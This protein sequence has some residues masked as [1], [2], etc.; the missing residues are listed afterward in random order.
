M[1]QSESFETRENRNVLMGLE[2]DASRILMDTYGSVQNGGYRSN[3]YGDEGD[4]DLYV[5][6]NSG[7]NPDCRGNY[8]SNGTTKIGEK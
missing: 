7:Y 5:N 3:V 1:L 4:D 6:S 8:F 2:K